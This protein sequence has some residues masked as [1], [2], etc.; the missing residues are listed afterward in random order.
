MTPGRSAAVALELVPHLVS[1]GVEREITVDRSNDCVVVDEAVFVK[2]LTPPV[3]T[4]HRGVDMVAHL[5]AVG[6]AHMPELFGVVHDGVWVAALIFE[7]VP[8]ARDGWEW[9]YE[10][11]LA[12]AD[13]DGS[14]ED[15]RLSA[16]QIGALTGELH[17]ALTIDSGTLPERARLINAATERDR[18][19]GLLDSALA[20]VRATDHPEAFAVLA[21]RQHRIGDLIEAMP[22]G[23]TMGIPVHGDLHLGQVL[24][25][26]DRLF[27]ID[28]DGNPLTAADHKPKPRPPAVDTASIIQSIDHAVRMAQHRRPDRDATFDALAIQLGETALDSY[29]RR[30]SHLLMRGLLDEALLPALRAAQELH[31]LVYSV[32]R[33]PRWIYA[34][35]LALRGMFP[36]D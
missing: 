36:D 32:R 6:F 7:Y 13:G 27:F 35:T 20:E 4:P 11:V 21:A 17:V 15:V 33:L 23:R 19:R 5:A 22:H 31:E 26:G 28:F 30:V 2:W 3:R 12:F 9:F 1:A 8:G 10:E 34:P 16:E 18:C 24:R 25:S 29:R 14:Y